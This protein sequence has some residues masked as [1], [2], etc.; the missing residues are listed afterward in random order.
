MKYQSIPVSVCLLFLASA[1]YGQ[2]WNELN[3]NVGPLSK[4]VGS[5]C[6][7]TIRAD[8]WQPQR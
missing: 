2:V 6:G 1:L 4:P 7:G 8:V 3:I 5:A